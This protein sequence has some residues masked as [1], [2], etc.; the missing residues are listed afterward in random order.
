MYASEVGLEGCRGPLGSGSLKVPCG[1]PFEL[2]TRPGL[3]QVNSSSSAASPFPHTVRALLGRSQ[4]PTQQAVGPKG[5]PRHESPA[6]N[7]SYEIGLDNKPRNGSPEVSLASL[8]NR[9]QA[10]PESASGRDF[11]QCVHLNIK[12]SSRV[13]CR[14]EH[15]LLGETLPQMLLAFPRDSQG[16]PNQDNDGGQDSAECHPD[17]GLC[18]LHLGLAEQSASVPIDKFYLAAHTFYMNSDNAQGTP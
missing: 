15:W 18:V 5:S 14:L 3:N 2:G 16:S 11:L 7:K 17:E 1:L 8:P 9:G 12:D 13:L 4:R 6:A 10:A